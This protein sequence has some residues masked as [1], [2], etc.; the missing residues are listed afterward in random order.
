M[1]HNNKKA[2]IKI[3][4]KSN[5]YKKK[6]SIFFTCL[7]ILVGVIITTGVLIFSE[8]EVIDN[9]MTLAY[10]YD[11]TFHDAPPTKDAG[12]EIDVINCDKAVGRWNNDKWNITLSE[13]EG[14]TTCVLTFK[15]K[16]P[17]HVLEINPN[18]GTY[19]GST[20]KLSVDVAET[21]TYELSL[22]TRRGYTFI[23][24][25]KDE[26]TSQLDGN[27]F[28]MGTENVKVKANWE[29]NSYRVEI[30]ETNLCDKVVT[31]EYNSLVAL[32]SPTKEGYTF[33]GWDVTSGTIN[34]DS[35]VVSDANAV[36]KPKWTLNNY[37][38]IV[39]HKKE[40]LDGTYTLADT[41]TFNAGYNVQVSPNTKTY[42][43]FTSPSK[44]TITISTENNSI[45]YQY[46]RNKYTLTIN[47]NGGTTSTLLSNELKYEESIQVISPTKRGY[48]FTGWT[49]TSGTIQDEMFTMGASNATLTAN[50]T[51]KRFTL[52]FDANQGS[53]TQTSK[54][55]VYDQTYG[56]LPTPT[57]TGYTFDG[58][59]INGSKIESTSTVKIEASTSAVAH[60]SKGAYTLS[61]NP[62][63]G[64]YNGSTATNTTSMDFEDEMPI[65]DPI[66]SGYT[67]AGWTLNGA[68]STY[69][70]S[71]KIFKMGSANAT[72]TAKWTK[73][74][75]KLTIEG[76]NV[77][78][79]VYNLD[80]LETY[81]LCEPQNEGHTFAGWDDH[82]SIIQGNLVTMKEKNSTIRAKW[83]A[84]TYNYIVYHNKMNLDGTTYTKVDA[85]T[86]N[87]SAEY[88]TVV[89]TEAK[90][91]PGFKAQENKTITIGIDSNIVNYYY[92][93][94]KYNLTIDPQGGSYF[95]QTYLEL[96]Y[97][98]QTTI[99]EISKDGYN[100]N[101]WTKSGNATL[102][103]NILTM[104]T[105]NTTLTASFTAKTYTVTFNA[106]GG[107][108][109]TTSK[110][111]T[112]DQTYGSLPT[113]VKT[114]SRFDGW[115]TA[116]SGGTKVTSNDL[117]K[118]TS[119]Q[120]LYAHWTLDY[121]VFGYGG[122][123]NVVMKKLSGSTSGSDNEILASDNNVITGFERS[124]TI[125]WN[126]TFGEGSAEGQAI[127]LWYD[128]GKIKWY[129]DA[130]K[131]YLNE[132]ADLMFYNMNNITSL[133]LT[134][135]NSSRSTSFYAMFG[136]MDNLASLNISTFDTSNVTDMSYLLYK[137]KKLTSLSLGTFNT[138]NATDM[139]HMF[140]GV[141]NLTTLN[142]SSFNTAK[143]EDMSYMFNNM[144]KV[145][146][147]NVS[148]FNTAKVTNM[149]Y[150]FNGV[151]KVTSLSL[152]SFNTANVTNMSYMF[153]Q[154]DSL[155]SINVNSFNTASV[156]DMTGMF[157]E[158][159]SIT[160]LDLRAF[161]TSKVTK[162]GCS[163]VTGI[164]PV[165]DTEAT[166]SV[167][168]SGMFAKMD[169]L[170][171]LDI[172]SFDTSKVQIMGCLFTN[173]KKITT[174]YASNKWSLQSV[175]YS[176]IMF[177]GDDAL[178]G[179]SG[180][181]Y[182]NSIYK[183]GSTWLDIDDSSFAKIDGGSSNKGY[184]TYKAN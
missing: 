4:L 69:N 85:D 56:A 135:I 32:C 177:M 72:L 23:G 17:V 10:M 166:Y 16:L 91:Y 13:I 25:E 120:T 89:V 60:W 146:S 67:F 11:G 158:M 98:E 7:T 153:S 29:I 51:A 70:S 116:A 54:E 3:N 104:G 173:C 106:N 40:A 86:Y 165:S 178:V 123:V 147:L 12:Y 42:T 171:T 136:E 118:I 14:K 110:T 137:D 71:T 113:P 175:T 157:A 150:M 115:Y 141:S 92:E 152:G 172:S 114:D 162:M 122:G 58:W 41:E 68:G 8:K 21:K 19:K 155:S 176:H 76:T 170:L 105:E 117:V 33:A 38:Y 109:T 34:G 15:K 154:M 6:I 151:S 75:Y 128:D 62:N 74:T 28:T 53:V 65:S 59:Y 94:E 145:T 182:D 126:N 160:N 142:V 130:S 138:S 140:D 64:T 46:T 63:G 80:Y 52:Y 43:G 131:V 169:N 93:R 87:S 148:S 81:P 180:S 36:V 168:A 44:Q 133:D 47:P 163:A 111:V 144:N 112:Y 96:L 61:I 37:N 35:F 31:V 22:P 84:N 101:G 125:D 77:C 139:S 73:N 124:S 30:K 103:D 179:G 132:D 181:A 9:K 82:D 2:V 100:F 159:P 164:T 183:S 149:A 127:Y 107:S 119:N 83:T 55:V 26:E 97:E 48:T 39:Y 143:V 88:G 18:G 161:N 78:D 50:Y 27:T 108:V 121:A 45:T 129:S 1:K 57:R 184:F 102:T 49:K 66:R 95:G 20:G 156:T 24:W 79:G 90:T 99:G 5:T 174:I 134:G 167:N